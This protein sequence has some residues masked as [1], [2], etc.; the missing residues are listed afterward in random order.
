MPRKKSKKI[1]LYIFLFLFIG[2]LNNKN[3][4]DINNKEIKNIYV[5]GLS[6][7]QNLEIKKSLEFYE[8]K[9]L[10][11][12][13]KIQIEKLINSFNHIEFFSVKK[14]YPSTLNIELIETKYLAYVIKDKNFFFLGSNGKLISISDQKK[15]LPYIY[16]SF[17][18]EKF[19]QLKKIL[20][21]LNFNFDEIEKLFY[22]PSGRWDMKL[23]N[24]ILIKLPKNR[25]EESLKLSIII[26]KD[27]NFKEK[28]MIDVRQLNQVIINE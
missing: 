25:L 21:K 15:V 16:G 13:E 23:R 24:G 14:K 27:K 9:N 28:S 20:D 26:L 4:K 6:E 19:F 7:K 3:I 18:I 8:L 12:L 5:S 10:F 17:E 11:F 22:F 1:F 2:T